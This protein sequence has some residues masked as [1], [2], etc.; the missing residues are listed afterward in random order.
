MTKSELLQAIKDK[1]PLFYRGTFF[2]AIFI[3]T[4]ELYGD[5]MFVATRIIQ[6]VVQHNRLRFINTDNFSL[7]TE[8]QK[9]QCNVPNI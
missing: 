9:K 3:P 8:S 7:A 6:G 4:G 1:T 5:N 2:D